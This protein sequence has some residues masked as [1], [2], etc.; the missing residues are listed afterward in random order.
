ML[1]HELGKNI[2]VFSAKLKGSKYH[3]EE[4]YD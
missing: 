1:I 3:A 4:N 2:S